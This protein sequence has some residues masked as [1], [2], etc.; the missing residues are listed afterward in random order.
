[1]DRSPSSVS[2]TTVVASFRRPSPMTVSTPRLLSV[3]CSPF[4]FA[5]TI[6][7]LYSWSAESS[8]DS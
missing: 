2:T 1:M 8:T 6:P 7:F 5:S 4:Q 3:A